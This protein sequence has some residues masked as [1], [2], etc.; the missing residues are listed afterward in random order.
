MEILIGLLVVTVLVIGWGYG[1]W[2]LAMFL[3]LGDL[4]YLAMIGLF[5]SADPTLQ[6][7]AI[8]SIAVIWAPFLIKRIRTMPIQRHDD[9]PTISL[10]SRSDDI[11]GGVLTVLAFGAVGWMFLHDLTD[12]WTLISSRPFL[13]MIGFVMLAGLGFGWANKSI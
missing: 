12:T 2:P 13:T 10:I 11:V 8:V 7:S 5:R 1:F 3:T 6:V 9:R 4:F